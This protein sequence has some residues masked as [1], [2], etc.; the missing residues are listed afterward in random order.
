MSDDP[1]PE[2]EAGTKAGLQRNGSTRG[3]CGRN[4]SN[5]SRSK[6]PVPT[7]THQNEQNSGV[8]ELSHPAPLKVEQGDGTIGRLTNASLGDHKVDQR[9]SKPREGITGD[10]VHRKYELLSGQDGASEV[11]VFDLAETSAPPS[12]EPGEG[13]HGGGSI[14]RQRSSS[15]KELAGLG[16]AHLG[17]GDAEVLMPRRSRRA[18]GTPPGTDVKDTRA[19]SNGELSMKDVAHVSLS[20]SN[21]Q[22]TDSKPVALGQ[23]TLIVTGEEEGEGDVEGVTRCV[24]GSTGESVLN[25]TI[26]SHFRRWV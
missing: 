17:D 8:H 6:G 1:F 23:A 5:R 21:T 18:A 20:K 26:T 14:R 19:P 7:K 10:M 9:P 3:L 15:M 16:L 13:P 12:E 4:R 11:A 25:R 22:R 2:D 24:C